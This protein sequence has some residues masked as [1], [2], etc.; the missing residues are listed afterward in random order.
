M[1]PPPLAK[2][3]ALCNMWLTFTLSFVKAKSCCSDPAGQEVLASRDIVSL[4]F[5]SVF[6]FFILLS[7][8]YPLWILGPE[9][10]KRRGYLTIYRQTMAPE[11]VFAASSSLCGCDKMVAA[12]CFVC[13]RFFL[14]HLFSGE[15]FL[16]V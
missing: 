14:S 15:G 7:P 3:A 11:A 16:F 5:S 2:L 1:Y 4:T 9:N 8:R 12:V 6:S 10:V 13:F